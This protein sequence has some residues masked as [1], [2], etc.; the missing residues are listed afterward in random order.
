ME[1][2]QLENLWGYSNNLK[3][4]INK[5]DRELALFELKN[6]CFELKLEVALKDTRVVYF[7]ELKCVENCEDCI[8]NH[9]KYIVEYL[10]N[11][12]NK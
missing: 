4:A 11:N 6:A 5:S 7:H 9:G 1:L 10:A 8:T 3:M 2:Q 12:S